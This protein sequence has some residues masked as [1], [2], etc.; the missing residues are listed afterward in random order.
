MI[1]SA[2]YAVKGQTQDCSGCVFNRFSN[3]LA[4][5]GAFFSLSVRANRCEEIKPAAGAMSTAE[6]I[7]RLSE[8]ANYELSPA[9]KESLFKCQKKFSPYEA[10]R[11]YYMMMAFD[12]AADRQLNELYAEDAFVPGK[13][14]LSD[15]NCEKY[16]TLQKTH[17]HCLELQKCPPRDRLARLSKATKEAYEE[18]NSIKDEN[19]SLISGRA[20]LMDPR[21]PFAGKQQKIAE[22]DE[23]IKANEARISQL[24]ARFPWLE[25]KAFKAA[26]KKSSANYESAVA[27]QFND[28]HSKNLAILDQYKNAADC[29]TMGPSAAPPGTCR[30]SQLNELM[31]NAPLPILYRTGGRDLKKGRESEEVNRYLSYSQC[32]DEARRFSS[33]TFKPVLQNELLAISLITVPFTAGLSLEADSF[34]LGARVAN[35]ANNASRAFT[36]TR[37]TT[38]GAA[39]LVSGGGTAITVGGALKNVYAQ[40]DKKI[41]AVTKWRQENP[42]DKVCISSENEEQGEALLKDAEQCFKA[43]MQLA[44]SAIPTAATIAAESKVVKTAVQ[45]VASKTSKVRPPPEG[46]GPTPVMAKGEA[47]INNADK[48]KSDL[49]QQMVNGVSAP[50]AEKVV[51]VEAEIRRTGQHYANVNQRARSPSMSD[52]HVPT[53]VPSDIVKN[54]AGDRMKNGHQVGELNSN[55][56]NAHAEVAVITEASREGTTLNAEMTIRVRGERPVCVHCRGDLTYAACA[57]GLLRLLV[58]TEKTG[59]KLYWQRAAAGAAGNAAAG[60][61]DCTHPGHFTSKAP[62]GWPSDWH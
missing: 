10:S 15:I 33:D 60:A 31:T 2:T 43:K 41:E 5:G 62:T 17:Q 3:L 52:E 23:K 22:L 42:E 13:K 38:S 30:E 27:A 9:A 53:Q 6:T 56:D 7:S 44:M 16:S 49:T 24:R 4:D 11:F 26:L 59:E 47:D 8:N 45:K 54:R 34:I 61:A 25:G 40:C 48:L 12:A 14:P 35:F 18:L 20:G 1:E 32:I 36:A 28:D 51:V 37:F 29:F 21:I 57:A 50:G 58:I 46:G 39:A 19:M 55:M